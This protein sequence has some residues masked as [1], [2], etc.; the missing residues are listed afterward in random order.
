[1][2]AGAANNQLETREMGA[3]LV[4]RGILYAPDY[5]INAGGIINVMG[6]I[7][8]RFDN[9]WVEGKLHTLKATLGEI[10]D[11]AARENRPSNIVSDELARQRLADAAEQK[12]LAAE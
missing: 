9:K 1:M 5:V 11:T 8:S 2:V 10:M 6:E 7:D 3:E 4:K 12:A